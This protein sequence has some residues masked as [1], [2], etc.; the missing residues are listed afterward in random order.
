MFKCIRSGKY[1]K[2]KAFYIAQASPILGS[3]LFNGLV[4]S[5]VGCHHNEFDAHVHYLSILAM[6]TCIQK[7]LENQSSTPHKPKNIDHD[8][9]LLECFSLTELSAWGGI[10]SR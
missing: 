3:A 5:W 6:P 7:S 4:V 1:R 2:T 9:N 8:N 10:H